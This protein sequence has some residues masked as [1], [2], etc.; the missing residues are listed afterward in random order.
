[1]KT[2]STLLLAAALAAGSTF[3]LAQEGQHSGKK[4]DQA[5]AKMES[6]RGEMSSSPIGQG[7][8]AGSHDSGA[9]P[10][11]GRIGDVKAT[12]N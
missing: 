11:P 7:G 8:T 1:M 6:N 12:G 2:V 10:G 5:P 4:S 9:K 3:A